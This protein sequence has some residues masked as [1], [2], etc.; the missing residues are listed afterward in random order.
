VPSDPNRILVRIPNWVGDVVMAT[1][2]I[3]ALRTR[4]PDAKIA[5]FGKPNGLT[6]LGGSPWF[7][8]GLARTD[9]LRANARIVQGFRPDLAVLMPNS[10]S[11]ALEALLALVAARVGYS[12]GGRGIILTTKCR[13]VMEGRRRLPIPMTRYYLELIE[14]I[15]G[16]KTDD[17][18]IE[19]FSGGE[20]EEAAGQWLAERRID[21]GERFIGV[22]PGASFGTSKLWRCDRFG[23]AAGALA[24]E[25]G[26]HVLLLNGPGEEALG[27]EVT[28]HSRA[29]VVNPDGAWVNLSVLK[30][31]V[32]RC[33]LVLTTD[34]GLRHVATAL[35]VPTV[36][37]M[38]PTDPR[39]T[40]SNL[41]NTIVLREDVDCAPC[42]LKVCPID[43]RCMERIEARRVI[44][45]GQRLL[46]DD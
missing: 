43:H 31:L 13:P 33:D 41:E 40:A 6:L 5:L 14:M 34:S 10:W 21:P 11:S 7:D 32:R 39:H 22:A 45:A 27:E 29:P 24:E 28:A 25:R 46:A 37:L 2:A 42:H 17:E 36:V 44:A 1:P 4:Y 30:A 18:R 26:Q 20:A 12:V 9:G 23:E 3:R 19:L 35:G 38:G 8:E 15:S 16:V